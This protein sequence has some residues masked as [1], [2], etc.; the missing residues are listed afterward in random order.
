MPAA[1]FAVALAIAGLGS[2]SAA[3]SLTPV[4]SWE[5][6]ALS[7]SA[8][9]VELQQAVACYDASRDA[10]GVLAV[11]RV[12]DLWGSFAYDWDQLRYLRIDANASSGTYGQVLDDTYLGWQ[13]RVDNIDCTSD[14]ANI[15]I[16]YDRK[17]GHAQWARMAGA[18]RHGP[19]AVAS[20]QCNGQEYLDGSTMYHYRPRISYGGGATP[21]IAIANNLH[22]YSGTDSDGS[23]ACVQQYS[24]TSGAPIAGTGNVYW[25]GGM[26]PG[27]FDIEWN[28]ANA[29]VWALPIDGDSHGENGAPEVD[30]FNT[31]TVNL[32]G[33]TGDGY[34]V[35]APTPPPE[36]MRT[37]L[38]Y[39]PRFDRFLWQTEDKS[40]WLD[41]Y[42]APLGATDNPVGSS[43]AACPHRGN[44]SRI[45]NVFAASVSWIQAGTWPN[46]FWWPSYRTKRLLLGVTAGT[47]PTQVANTGYYPE[48][49]AASDDDV[50]LVSRPTSGTTPRI[51]WNLQSSD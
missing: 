37:R 19:Y 47:Y 13:W 23:R 33:A 4:R 6:P 18:V 12:H 38:V 21:R 39:S 48:A 22:V 20:E 46:V 30:F 5:A 28:G 25:Y 50:L 32:S 40:Y 29:W 10:Y 27:D 2:S 35:E 42:G 14:G 51:Y 45:A 36:S 34:I 26:I 16:A 7:S 24:P 3:G 9:G 31:T 17:N 44:A 43:V 49:C 41:R 15:Y 1:T 8:T 11:F